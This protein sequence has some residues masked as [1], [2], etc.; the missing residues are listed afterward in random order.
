MSE[1]TNI[2]NVLKYLVMLYYSHLEGCFSSSGFT[3][4]I[5]NWFRK[6]NNGSI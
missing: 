6:S 3:H 5:V 1:K 4:T 2:L